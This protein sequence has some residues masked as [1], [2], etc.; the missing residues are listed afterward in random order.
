[1]LRQIQAVITTQK[2]INSG[3]RVLVAVSGGPDSVALLCILNELAPKLG[4]TLTVAHLNHAIRGK[5]ADEDAVFVRQLAAH[6][7]LQCVTEKM[8]VPALARRNGWSLEMAAREARYAFFARVA[9]SGK[10]AAVATAHNA[11]DQAETV[12][13]K[14]A[15][16]AGTGG[17]AG[18]RP[19]TILR[20]IRVIRPLLTVSRTDIIEFLKT[21]KQAWREDESN[22]DKT[23]LRN[24][25][26][27]EVLPMLAAKL[28]PGIK[29]TLCRTA[30][31]MQDEDTWLENLAV[32]IY[33][34]CRI[35]NSKAINIKVLGSQPRAALRR[36]L[37]LWMIKTGVPA[38]LLSFDSIA[39]MENLVRKKGG[40]TDLSLGGGWVAKRR[41]DNLT[42]KHGDSDVSFKG[43]KMAL[44]IPGETLASDGKLRIVTLLSPGLIKQQTVW[45]GALPARASIG[46][47]R[48][49]RKKIF[50]RSWQTGDRMKP[51][52]M[53]GSK[54][55][56]DIFVDA[57]VPIE[58]RLN[59]PVLE[60]GGEIIWLPGYRVAR[61]WEV[62]DPESTALQV[63]IERI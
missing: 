12:L 42:I 36:V 18:I 50:V 58:Q 25:V 15:R 24:R 8:D 16:G 19:M 44:K 49:G 45:P 21:R 14:L 4:I 38:E 31:L 28:N 54:K 55:L 62:S 27:H 10:L 26:R 22:N 6:F 11:D 32:E 7:G 39:G 59:I 48:I 13:L 20:G 46:R 63:G 52:G 29:N 9:G 34:T 61:G 40:S 33:A 2:L 41:Y 47:S 60:C 5:T 57:K 35:R 30:A 53:S 17:L 23:F 37:R 3:E 56:Q 43:Y 51:L 1:M